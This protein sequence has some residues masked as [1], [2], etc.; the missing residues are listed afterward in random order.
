MTAIREAEIPNFL[1]HLET[2][3]SDLRE[4]FFKAHVLLQEREDTLLRRLQEIENDFKL[5]SVKEA[6]QRVELLIAKEKLQSFIKGNENKGTLIEMLTPLEAKLNELDKRGGFIEIV[7]EGERKLEYLLKVFGTIKLTSQDEKVIV[8]TPRLDYETKS[9]PVLVACKYK[10]DIFQ[11]TGKF[12]NPTALVISP[13]SQLYVIDAVN[14]RIQVFDNSCKFLFLI[15][16]NMNYPAGICFDNNNK[17]YV[18]QFSNNTLNVYVGMRCITT[19]GSEGDGELEFKRPLGI[20][21]SIYSNALYI[22]ERDNNRVQVL[23]YDLSFDSYIIGLTKPVDVKVSG[24]E[25]FILDRQSPCFH[26]FNLERQLI[27][28]VISLGEMGCN[29]RKP[30]H[31]CLDP[32]SNILLTD[33]LTCEVMIFTKD[34]E[35]IH[36]FGRKGISTGCFIEPRGIALDSEGRIIVASQNPNHCIQFF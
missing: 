36:K 16:E 21:Y 27:R 17:I 25:L 34:G 33:F 7:W 1:K 2:V 24:G 8:A 9:K 23:N 12:K 29:V 20:C 28:E 18:T 4:K 19:V 13:Q 10:E 22:C 6:Q 30:V 14:N 5:Q 32:L 15:S 11:Q 26:I 3:R 31:F 35:L